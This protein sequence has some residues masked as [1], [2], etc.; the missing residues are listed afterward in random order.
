MTIVRSVLA[1]VRTTDQAMMTSEPQTCGDA[2]KPRPTLQSDSL[3]RFAVLLV[4]L[5]TFLLYARTISYRFVYDD[6]Y[7]ILNNNRVLSWHYLPSYFT[8]SFWGQIPHNGSNLYRPFFLIWLRFNMAVWGKDP[9]GWHLMTVLVNVLVAGLVYLVARKLLRH[10]VAAIVAAAVFA[11][12]PVHVEAVAW[13]AGV[14]EPLGTA[15][16]LLAFLCYLRQRNHPTASVWRILSLLLFAAAVL[17]KETEAVLPFLII[18]YECTIGRSS[19][20]A[21]RSW[22]RGLVWYFAVI[23]VCFTLRTLAMRG[24]LNPGEA[25]VHDSLLSVPW[26]VCVYLKMLFWPGHLSPMY[27]FAYVDHA[28]ASG[29]IIGLA[30]VVACITLAGWLWKSGSMLGVFLCG[31]FAV[32]LAPALAQFFLSFKSESYHD[33][34]LY[35]PSFA[36]AMVAAL[37]FQRVLVWRSQLAHSVLYAATALLLGVMALITW[38]QQQYW[39]DNYS[40][41]QHATQVAPQNERAAANYA[42]ELINNGELNP[43]LALSEQMM[44]LH[45]NS[46]IPVRPAALAAFLSHDFALAERYYTRAVE[47]DPSVGQMYFLLGVTRMQLGHYADAV[48]ALKKSLFLSPDAF[49]IHYTLGLA[50]AKQGQWKDARDQFA[51]EISANGHNL[52][53]AQA[54]NDAESHL[55][56]RTLAAARLRNTSN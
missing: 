23:A 3:C 8:Q 56:A 22:I 21:D 44:K 55:Q 10:R 7:Q 16:L 28:M 33:R 39:Q 35:L 29:F 6:N 13:I 52:L 4:L 27:D 26:L 19:R 5:A 32:T 49:R 48:E 18:L 1:I 51:A 50:L 11:F 46:V 12:H 20:P 9:W 15:L 53:A 42:A 24:G 36:L 40:L 43:A 34:Y 14:T 17:T 25:S 54:L 47:L 41:F 45:P 37:A 2:P 31:W 38:Q 30:I